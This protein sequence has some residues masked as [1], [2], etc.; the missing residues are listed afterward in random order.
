MATELNLEQKLADLL[1]TRNF[2]PE[3]LGKDGRPAEASEAKTFSFDYISGSGKNYGTM[4][5]VLGSD[6]EMYIMYGDNLGKT[7]EDT[8]D[9]SEFFDFQQQLMDLANR[10][11]WSGTLMDISKLKRVQAGIAAIKEGLFEGYYG[12][13]KIS[14]TGEP[15]EARLMIKHNRTL[16]ENDARFRYVESV[17]IETADGERFKLPFTNMSGARAMLEHVRQGGKP[18]DIRGNHICEMVTEM[19]VLNRFNRAAGHRVME[20]VTQQIVEQAQHYYAKLRESMKQL[21]SSRGYKNYF[22]SWHPLDIQEQESLVEDIKTMFIEQTLDTRIEAALPL[23]ARI[24]QQGNTMKEADIFESWVNKLVEGTWS[25]PETPEQ[26]AK[27]K[28]LM[29]KELIVGPDATNATEQLYDLVG[30]DELFDRLGELAQR[31]PRANVW[32]DTEV[33][34]R[35]RELGIETEGIAPAGAEGDVAAEQPPAEVPAPEQQPAVAED[36]DRMLALAGVVNEARILDESGETLDHILDRFKY[37][38]KQFQEG[39]DLDDDLYEALFDYYANAGEMPY[40][41]MK[42]RTGDPYEWITDRLDQ[43]LGTGNHAPRQVPEADALQT[44]E[45]DS[46]AVFGEGSGCNHTMEGEYCPEHGLM[47][48]GSYM[49]SM[50]GTVA[51]AVAP[52]SEVSADTLKK[53]KTA[54]IKDVDRDIAAKAAGTIGRDEFERKMTK[55]GRGMAA[56]DRRLTPHG[57]RLDLSPHGDSIQKD[58]DRY[59]FDEQDVAEGAK[60]HSELSRLAHEA[61]IAAVRSGNAQMANHYKQAYEKHKRLAASER[62]SAAKGMTEGNDDPMNY[63]AAITSSYYESADPLARIKELALRK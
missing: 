18:Y 56:A 35:L 5:V 1:D 41:T 4:V 51:G 2:H 20:G 21:G 12:T 25:L 42:A 29:T 26:N 55:R 33:M 13:R 37:E 23:L 28:E 17:F 6:N 32:N 7:I 10:N 52:V 16:S 48:C 15:T 46:A 14:Y 30:D 27:L 39:G 3:M 62:K 34:N 59:R 47:E 31:D 60:S 50:G 54:A 58:Y 40:G 49:E 19:K 38:V 45:A 63:N 61:Y 44:F 22:E 9:R 53:Y 43:E 11:R 8:D 36:F 57:T 24:Q